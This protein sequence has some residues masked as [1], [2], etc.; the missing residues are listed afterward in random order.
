VE[1][2]SVGWAV[3]YAPRAAIIPATAASAVLKR[4]AADRC[5][6]CLGV[7]GTVGARQKDNILLKD[8]EHTSSKSDPKRKPL[9]LRKR[10]ATPTLRGLTVMG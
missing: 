7:A 6:L 1:L 4:D 2:R 8:Q 10:S 5:T 3:A 9:H